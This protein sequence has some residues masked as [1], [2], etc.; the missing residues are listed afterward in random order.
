MP[1]WLNLLLTAP[2]L[3]LQLYL[4]LLLFDLKRPFLKLIVIAMI[5]AA[6][7]NAL[8]LL[9]G[10]FSPIKII[11][12][13]IAL[14]CLYAYLTKTNILK[15][16]L[17]I[18]MGGNIIYFIDSITL[19]LFYNLIKILPMEIVNDS[20]I[21]IIGV[22]FMVSL[23]LGVI[24]LIKTHNWKLYSLSQLADNENKEYKTIL[25]TMLVLVGNASISL[26]FYFFS[27]GF[28][29]CHFRLVIS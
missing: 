19:F 5:A 1:V 29:P 21:S 10:A 18:I 12:A 7:N 17:A 11:V 25:I 14:F 26:L 28:I 15:S 22:L 9:L 6:T 13:A 8:E 2:T 27:D 23:G 24:T 20:L 3:L 4:G 16:A